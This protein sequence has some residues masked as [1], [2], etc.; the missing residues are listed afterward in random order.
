MNILPVRAELFHVDG[1][2]YRHEESYSR[3]PQSYESTLHGC[4]T[5]EITVSGEVTNIKRRN[6]TFVSRGRGFKS[7]SK[8]GYSVTM[9]F[10][11][12]L[13]YV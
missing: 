8:T 7:Q 10:L 12:A 5:Y 2:T 9:I 3:L 6:G 1:W 4:E 13:R 11:G